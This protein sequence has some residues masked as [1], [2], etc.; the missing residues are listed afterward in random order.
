MEFLQH[1]FGA[2]GVEIVAST[3]GLLCVY[4]IIKRHMA[5]WPVGL[6]QVILYI[7][8]FYQAKLY[9]DMVLHIIYVFMQIYGWWYWAQDKQSHAGIQIVGLHYRT[10]LGW[11]VAVLLGSAILG[12]VMNTYTNADFAYGDAFTTVASLAA[13]WLLS[14]RMLANWL[15]WI[16]VD[17][18]AIGIYWQKAL[19]PTAVLYSLFFVMACSGLGLWLAEYRRQNA[20]VPQEV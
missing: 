18:V 6:L 4:L 11:L 8:V 19:I 14:R 9:S 2:S 16:A 5:C 1:M 12:G 20:P 13:Q 17:I 15:F 10:V 7:Y 3:A